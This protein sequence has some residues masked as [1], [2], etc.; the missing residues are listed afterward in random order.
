MSAPILQVTPEEISF[1]TTFSNFVPGSS[2]RLGVG[3]TGDK[4]NSTTIELLKENIVLSKKVVGFEQGF[5][6]SW[7]EVDR[8]FV[9]GLLFRSAELPGSGEDLTLKVTL[10]RAEA[11]RLKRLFVILA[12]QYGPDRWYIVEGAE[13]NESHW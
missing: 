2:Y 9:R 11:D 4:T 6:R 7:F 10:P 13:L 12:K 3:T 1:T 8:I 5:A